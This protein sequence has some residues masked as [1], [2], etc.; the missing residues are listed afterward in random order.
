MDRVID[1]KPASLTAEPALVSFA[2]EI[3]Y[4]GCYPGPGGSPICPNTH[5]QIEK[6]GGGNMQPPQGNHTPNWN[7]HPPRRG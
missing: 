4:G 3:Y 5:S 2:Q 7:W 6:T 1:E